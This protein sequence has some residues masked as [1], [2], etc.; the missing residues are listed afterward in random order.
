MHF[1][2]IDKIKNSIKRNKFL[3]TNTVFLHDMQFYSFF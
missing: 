1:Y 3:I 2:Q